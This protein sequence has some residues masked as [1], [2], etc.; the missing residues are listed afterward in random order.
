MTMAQVF[1]ELLA[2]CTPERLLHDP[3]ATGEGVSVCI[4]DSGVE[5]AVL[6]Q[7]FRQAG[8]DIHPVQGGI[9]TAEQ[10]QPLP[11]DGKQ[12]TPHGTTVADI[13][14]TIAPRAR[15]YSADVFGPRG[16]CEVEVVIKAL[17]WAIEV[18]GRGRG[19][20]ATVAPA[21]AIRAGH[22]GRLLQGRAGFRRRPQRSSLDAELSGLVRSATHECGQEPVCRPLTFH[23]RLA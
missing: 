8:Q 6:E 21:P 3:R 22:P 17:Y 11:Y 16:S 12:S 18:A 15:L 13:V 19:A 1:D 20:P 7:K 14:L 9:F 2:L 10:P 5:Q 23:L 4:I